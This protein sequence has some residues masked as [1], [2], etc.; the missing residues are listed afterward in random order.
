MV[1]KSLALIESLWTSSPLNLSE[2][3]SLGKTNHQSFKNNYIQ[4]IYIL[5]QINSCLSSH[6]YYGNTVGLLFLRFP[7]LPS[8]EIYLDS[9]LR[10]PIFLENSSQGWFQTVCVSMA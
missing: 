7:Y 5:S 10:P 8:W 9:M 1:G 4:K 6:C 2:S 3:T